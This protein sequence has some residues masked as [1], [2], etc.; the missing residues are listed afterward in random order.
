V[1][2]LSGDVEMLNPIMISDIDRVSLKHILIKGTVIQSWGPHYVDLHPTFRC[3]ICGMI[4]AGENRF[5]YDKLVLPDYCEEFIGG[6]GRSKNICKFQH[7]IDNSVI[8]EKYLK[9]HLRDVNIDFIL[10]LLGENKAPTIGDQIIFESTIFPRTNKGLI[11]RCWE[12]EGIAYSII[13]DC[14]L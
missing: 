12:G 14:T 3:S 1:I 6:C 8:L 13:D 11:V 9:I 2:S 5:P 4:I 10:T 7:I